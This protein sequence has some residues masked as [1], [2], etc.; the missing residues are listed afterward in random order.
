MH[1]ITDK[2]FITAD[3]SI[4]QLDNNTTMDSEYR[5][6][7]PYATMQMIIND[8]NF[9]RNRYLETKDKKWW[10]QIIQLLPMSYNQ[11]RTV[12]MNYENVVTIINQRTGHKLDEWN[13]LVAMFK[14]LPYI[15]EIIDE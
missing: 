15:E 5:R 8:L 14:E 13:N 3:F 2:E 7:N 12:T 9:C 6:C 10:W 1:K 11:K 4:E